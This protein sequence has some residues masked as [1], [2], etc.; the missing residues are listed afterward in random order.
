MSRKILIYAGE[1][2][3]TIDLRSDTVTLPPEEMRKAM[4][5]AEL[6]DDVYGEDPSVNKLQEAAAA[7][8]GMEAGLFV[9]SGSMGNFVAMLSH[10]GRGD[11]ALLGSDSHIYV[12]EQGSA[13]TLGGIHMK[14]LP[15][16]ED[17]TMILS[18]IEHAVSPDDDHYART[19]L[20]ALE[21][22]I[23][24]SVIKTAYLKDF[25]GLAKKLGLATHL[26]GARV[27]N[28]AVCLDLKPADL[29]RGFDSVQFC[30]SKGLSAP[31]GSMLCGRKDFIKQARR[32]PK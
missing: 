15:T 25:V 26:D 30:F 8:M 27:F 19:R 24:G 13:S 18:D 31:A 6:G 1:I 23:N 11:E 14:A 12:H 28:A 9:P 3:K 17:G 20:V 21:N 29:T 5:S 4:Y 22:T 7:A 10:L 2:M 16:Q 32:W